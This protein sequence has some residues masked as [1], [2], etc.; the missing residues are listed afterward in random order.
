MGVL[1]PVGS[2]SNPRSSVN[3]YEHHGRYGYTGKGEDCDRSLVSGNSA[4]TEGSVAAGNLVRNG[5]RKD[6]LLS[7]PLPKRL[8]HGP[9][10]TPACNSSPEGTGISAGH[11][12]A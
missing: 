1:F 6:A 3:E 7:D 12:F 2:E 8:L 5:E 10:S 11:G 4:G 9:H